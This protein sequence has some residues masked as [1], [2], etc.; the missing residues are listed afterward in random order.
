MTKPV[1]ILEHLSGDGPAYLGQ[2][3]QRHGIASDV[4]NS[5]AGDV[6]PADLKGYRAVAI[7]GGEMS[8]ND[9]LPML[10]QVEHL[11][12]EGVDHGIPVIGHCLG[13]QLMARALGAQV[14]LSPLP[15]VGWH[16]VQFSASTL[17]QQW[18]GDAHEANVFQW[19]YD[20]FALP[21]GAVALAGNSA[22]PHQAF[23]LGPH[24]AMQ[25]HIEVD[26]K[27]LEQWL[28]EQSQRYHTAQRVNATV[29]SVE[30]MRDGIQ[31][32]L[33]AQQK[34]ANRVY[35]RWMSDAVM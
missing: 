25:F 23:C 8:A 6:F 33:A 22:C 14:G 17:A 5:E 30:V 10:R 29:Q 20:A 15:E 24:L 19:H 1:L 2:W 31:L 11:V 21:A 13:G 4:R 32:H 26:A 3:L 16:A 35:A 34:L 7:L 28:D 12:R 9:D 18:F 27:K